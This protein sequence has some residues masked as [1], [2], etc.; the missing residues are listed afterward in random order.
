MAETDFSG[1]AAKFMGDRSIYGK[2]FNIQRFSIHDGPG[3]R[4]TVF[5]SGCPLDCWWC[6][7]PES[8]DISSAAD[9]DSD[10]LMEEIVKDLIFMDE[11]EGGVTFSGGEPLLQSGFLVEIAHRCKSLGIHTV[12]DTSGCAPTE[13]ILS[14]I[15]YID[16]V[17]FDLKLTSDRQHQKYTGQSNRAVL[18]SLNFLAERKQ[19]LWF[20]FPVVPGI[21][22]TPENISGV[23][24]LVRS[25]PLPVQ[26]HLL[27]YH[28]CA[29]HKYRHLKKK[30]RLNDLKTV[31]SSDLIP[32]AEEF[33]V[34]G[35]PVIIGG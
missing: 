25:Y 3:I 19:P 5:F 33:E 18:Q 13:H 11:S 20:R 12:L 16:L 8:Q 4:T 22:D 15:E 28:R 17:L 23:I 29:D 35:C 21:T 7:N 6:H 27:P 2:I 31:S 14:V 1:F 30:N 26:T 24:E 10:A 9:Y 34:H 32:L